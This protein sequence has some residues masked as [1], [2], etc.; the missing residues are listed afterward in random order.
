[1]ETEFNPLAVLSE[2]LASDTAVCFDDAPGIPMFDAPMIAVADAGDALFSR[3][4]EVIG[5]F[6]WSPQEALAL[7]AP[8][9]TARSV[10]CWCL[11]I[12]STARR[13]NRR[14]K[15]LP[16]RAWAYV[17]TFGEELNNRLRSGM[18]LRL[19]SL[20]FA[21]VAPAVLPQNTTAE[22]PPA[23]LCS[24]WSERH[25]AFVAGLG[26]FGL[27]G[28]L[29]TVRGIAHRLG[30]V[31]TDA[32]LAPT[33]RPY[34]DDPF[35]WCLRLKQGT[36]GTCIKRCPVN[37]IGESTATRDKLV[38]QRYYKDTINAQRADV[39]LWKGHYGCGLCQT[40]VPCEDRIPQAETAA[41]R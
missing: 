31:V 40:G 23:G 1:M 12:N 36:C 7:A 9:A 17:R 5:P 20:G 30:S 26:T 25:T 8:A 33:P 28:G 22:R 39:F 6:Y 37:S 14:E 41:R 4:K 11:P 38:C 21:A 15:L 18:E 34:G 32:R 16:G 35:A 13:A 19:R 24:C 3:L 10:V 29:I 27:S 2:L